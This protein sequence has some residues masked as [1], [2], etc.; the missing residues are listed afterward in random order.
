MVSIEDLYLSYGILADAK[1]KAGEV[2][3]RH[4]PLILSLHIDEWNLNPQFVWRHKYNALAISLMRR[5]YLIVRRL[6]R[7]RSI[8]ATLI[9][10]LYCNFIICTLPLRLFFVTVCEDTHKSDAAVSNE[11][12]CVL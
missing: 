4:L 11:L 1:A 10:V 9:F 8:I 5:V 6:V 12:T 2:S 7:R 3:A